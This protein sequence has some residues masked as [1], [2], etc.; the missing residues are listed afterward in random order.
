M[1]ELRQIF[2]CWKIEAFFSY[3][4][5]DGIVGQCRSYDALRNTIAL[6]HAFQQ[7][8]RENEGTVFVIRQG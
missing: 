1:K 8:C 7:V 3:S 4:R 2:A 5:A 6:L